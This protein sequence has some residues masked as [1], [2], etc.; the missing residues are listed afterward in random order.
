MIYE[1]CR[2]DGPYIQPSGRAT[3]NIH[4]A[5]GRTTTTHY[6][7]Y[8]MEIHLNRY[9]ESWEEVDHKDDNFMND[10]IEN[11]QILTK[12]EN[13]RKRI[14][15]QDFICPYCKKKFTIFGEKLSDALC[16]QNKGY[17]GPF[18]SKNCSSSNRN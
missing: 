12:K 5:N 18:C 15:S 11:L 16:K 7:R 6:A 8:L 9:L 13:N 1:N 17:R 14:R 3:V 10:S 2:I 4:F